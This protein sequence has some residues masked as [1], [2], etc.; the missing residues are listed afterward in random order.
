M[1]RPRDSRF[2]IRAEGEVCSVT[3]R[4]GATLFSIEG[5]G[6]AYVYACLRGQERIEQSLVD[7]SRGTFSKESFVADLAKSGYFS[8]EEIAAVWKQ[9]RDTRQS[10]ETVGGSDP[11]VTKRPLYRTAGEFTRTE[12]EKPEGNDVL[13]RTKNR[14]ED[15]HVAAREFMRHARL[16]PL[17]T[18]LF[19]S[20]VSGYD[21]LAGVVGAHPFPQLL[22]IY[23][24]DTKVK[25]GEL[26]RIHSFIVLGKSGED[27]V[28]FEK[29]GTSLAW[30]L[31]PLKEIFD[32]YESHFKEANNG[33]PQ[34]SWSVNT[35]EPL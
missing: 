18:E 22:E 8:E 13:P 2:G 12:H 1:V 7:H 15:C 14:S 3:T 30:R 16:E 26:S 23:S 10:V 27:L 17:S 29:V 34:I 25:K 4:D 19:L 31:A 28:C 5:K 9:I 32:M 33:R 6:G 21:Q 20:E 11:A 24:R 35:L